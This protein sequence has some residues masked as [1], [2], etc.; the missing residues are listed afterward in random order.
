MSKGVKCV[1][2]GYRFTYFEKPGADKALLIIGQDKQVLIK[3]CA[4]YFNSLGVSF[5]AIG[6]NP[7]GKAQPG[8]HSLP[9]ECIESVIKW[10]RARGIRKVGTMGA[11]TTGMLALA[12]AAYVSDISIAIACTPCDYIMQGFFQGKLDGKIPEWPASGESTLTRGGK[13]LPYAP[14]DLSA[15]EYYDLS[16]GKATKDAGELNATKV[17]SHIEENG[18]PDEAKI[19]IERINGPV[20]VFGAQDD[21]LWPTAMYIRRM[22]ER[23]KAHGRDNL[24]AHVYTYGT[25]LMFPQGLVDNILPFGIKFILGRVFK[26]AKAHPD[27]CAQTRRDVD[28]L[29]RVAIE[30][31]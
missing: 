18:I 13:A 17:F 4:K 6:S 22:H 10:L 2:D 9:L 27:E 3:A 31:W 16:Y 19:P 26:S 30:K 15:Q 21:T 25:H 24:H 28:K 20:Y 12:V 7:T 1:Q 14:Y 11:S 5:V 29:V 23:M 8:V